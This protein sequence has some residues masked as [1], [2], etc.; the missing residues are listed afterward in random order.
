MEHNTGTQFKQ[1]DQKVIA[2]EQSKSLY[3]FFLPHSSN[4]LFEQ[5]QTEY[6]S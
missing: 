3:A 1:A 4:V 2:S 5:T 6:M